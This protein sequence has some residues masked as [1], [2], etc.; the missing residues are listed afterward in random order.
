[1]LVIRLVGV[2]VQVR[3]ER[4]VILWLAVTELHLQGVQHSVVKGNQ[5]VVLIHLVRKLLVQKQ[6]TRHLHHIL[7]E[8][9]RLQA[10]ANLHILLLLIVLLAP[11]AIGV[12]LLSAG[13]GVNV[14]HL[15]RHL[16]LLAQKLLCNLVGQP[17]LQGNA[18]IRL[19]PRVAAEPIPR[20]R[21]EPSTL[22]LLAI[23]GVDNH[24]NVVLRLTDARIMN[25]TTDVGLLNLKEVL[26]IAKA[27][28]CNQAAHSQT[29]AVIAEAETIPLGIRLA[30]IVALVLCAKVQPDRL[31]VR[32]N[33]LETDACINPQRIV[34]V[35]VAQI[36]DVSRIILQQCLGQRLLV[37][38]MSRR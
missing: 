4:H 18:A 31:Q 34:L 24:R 2:V 10:V 30:E 12:L 22:E 21:A 17:D 37:E 3:G 19:L 23:H 16:Q 1:M 29:I 15:A 8:T 28:P 11:V 32:V 14:H 26:E 13:T 9:H 25:Q 7:R 36:A 27:R 38:A 20:R 35:T 5:I 6:Q 33:V